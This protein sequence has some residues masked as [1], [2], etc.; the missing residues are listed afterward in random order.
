MGTF[1][2]L[3]TLILL[4]AFIGLV[5]WLFFFRR[6][7]DFDEAARLPL[8]GDNQPRENGHE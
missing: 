3:I 4:L 2:G 6:S 7:Q 5:V 8:D 1:R